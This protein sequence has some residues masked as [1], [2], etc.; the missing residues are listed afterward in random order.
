MR[1]QYYNEKT[2]F[3][4]MK[5][6]MEKVELAVWRLETPYGLDDEGIMMY[7][8]Y[9]FGKEAEKLVYE[10]IDNNRVSILPLLV[11][12]KLIKKTNVTKLTD[13]ARDK[14]KTDILFYLMEAGNQLKFN[15]RNLVT[16]KKHTP[17]KTALPP[18]ENTADYSDAKPGQLI[19]LGYDAMPWQVLENKEGRLLVI[20]KF[21]LECLPID[22]FYKGYWDWRG[23]TIR[24]LLNAEFVN[25]MLT[26]EEQEKIIPVYIDNNTDLH[27]GGDGVVAEDKLF[28]ISLAD[29]RRYF[30]SDRDRMAP[31]TKFGIRSMLWTVFDQYGH[32][33]TRTKGI[34]PLD[35]YYIRDGVPMSENSTVSGGQQEYFGV[36]PAMYYKP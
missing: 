26:K 31:I 33:W 10:F 18:S 6:S 20:S 24:R 3:K 34:L 16:A 2:D 11:K 29:A 13:Y 22:R 30:K 35:T 5:S 32:W 23:C 12:Y 9:L 15:A 7:Q 4:R 36:R 8:E 19:F 27:F 21:V 25:D 14:K 1:T 28:Y 17:G